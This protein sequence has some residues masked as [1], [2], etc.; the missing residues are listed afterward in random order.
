MA[1]PYTFGSATTSI[2]LSQLDSNF[3]TTIT[4]GNTSIQLGNTVTTL[5]NMTF[6]NVTI[7]SV[8]TAVTPAQGG[9]GLTTLT[10]NNVLLGNGTSS[11]VFVAPGTSG[12]V[13]TSNGTTWASSAPSGKGPAFAAYL[14]ANQSVASITG[15]TFACD[16]KEF[17][18][19][20]C[21]N[22]TGSTVT[23]NGLSVPA[24]SF[25]PNVAGSYIVNA[26]YQIG[27]VSSFS[28]A[29]IT[30][31]KNGSNYKRLIDTNSSVNE[32]AGTT[33]VYLNGTGDYVNFYGYISATGSLTFNGGTVDLTWFNGSMVRSA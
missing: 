11:V 19:A 6:A 30:C 3:A 17:D 20:G 24:Y 29:L 1:V 14:S 5:N 18:T 31:S 16:T 23:L 9:T 4:L 7:S 15:T 21:Y 2:P 13:L 26:G 22:N 25:C 33:I 27:G 32:L 12:N 8:S 10:A 28:R